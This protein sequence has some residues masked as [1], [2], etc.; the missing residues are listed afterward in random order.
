MGHDS[1]KFTRKAC[2]KTKG[3]LLKLENVARNKREQGHQR[4]HEQPGEK[5]RSTSC[6]APK[7]SQITVPFVQCTEKKTR[8]HKKKKNRK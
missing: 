4:A 8:L 1:R 7:R 6:P 3:D 5:K 2:Q